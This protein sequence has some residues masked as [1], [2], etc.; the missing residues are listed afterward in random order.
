MRLSS[1][2]D[3]V[4]Q[5]VT[6]HAIAANDINGTYI[7]SASTNISVTCLAAPLSLRHLQ[8]HNLHAAWANSSSM[9]LHLDLHQAI[10]DG[11]VPPALSHLLQ[12]DLLSLPAFGSLKDRNG[13]T[14]S[15]PKGAIV[16][17]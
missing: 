5:D 11:S 15:F 17:P 7:S 8:S 3:M 16:S 10:S 12:F 9:V 14:L 2:L 6:V 1:D 4:D 13:V